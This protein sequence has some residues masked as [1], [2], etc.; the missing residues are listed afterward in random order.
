MDKLR[1]GG[2]GCILGV[3]AGALG[4]A[5]SFGAGLAAGAMA[6]GLGL[7]SALLVML[8]T[9]GLNERFAFRLFPAGGILL[10]AGTLATLAATVAALG[11]IQAAM[12][13]R[14]TA[15]L[16]DALFGIFAAGLV[17]IAGWV[18]I[19]GSLVARRRAVAEAL[20]P[21]RETFVLLAGVFLILVLIPFVGIVLLGL[22][23]F[24]LAGKAPAAPAA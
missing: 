13:A 22:L 12:A 21:G 2:F 10:V 6:Y 24:R 5:G 1:L 16:S 15:A 9:F 14:D 17:T 4:V 11:A 23:F 7:L 20:G 19:G 8:G 18:L 3:A